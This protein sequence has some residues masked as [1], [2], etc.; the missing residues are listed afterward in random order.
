MPLPGVLLCLLLPYLLC[1]Y[2]QTRTNNEWSEIAASFCSYNYQC[3]PRVTVD[4]VHSVNNT[5]WVKLV[6]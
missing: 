3:I 1:I 5:L 6:R 4:Q 2:A